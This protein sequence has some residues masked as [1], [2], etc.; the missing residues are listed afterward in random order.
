M[1][2]LEYDMLITN[3]Q[4]SMPT[5]KEIFVD[6]LTGERVAYS[7]STPNYDEVLK[8]ITPTIDMIKSEFIGKIVSSSQTGMAEKSKMLLVKDIHVKKSY[9]YPLIVVEAVRVKNNFSICSNKYTFP[10]S[11]KRLTVLSRQEIINQLGWREPSM[12]NFDDKCLYIIKNEIGR[13]KIGQAI[14]IDAR[15]KQ[16]RT[17]S[18]MDL[19]LLR[20]IQNAAWLEVVLH[21][22]FKKER[23]I[24]EWFN[25]SQEQID[26]VVNTD[27]EAYFNNK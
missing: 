2:S 23:Y 5:K 13:I 16:L 3:I 7:T 19:V 18:G 6:E 21:R 24:G 8:A 14:D 17:S 26:F 12:F 25:L 20:K 4:T 22:H 9:I 27:I 11:R 1:D 10:F 15:I